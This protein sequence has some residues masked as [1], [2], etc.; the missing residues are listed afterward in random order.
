MATQFEGQ[1][2]GEQ[3]IFTFR[4]HPI[5]MRKG[6]YALAIPFLIASI[7]V[8]IWPENISNLWIAF[9]GLAL[10]LLLFFYHW[11]GWYFSIFIV[12]D[13]RLRQVTQ[14]GFF[15]RSVID[16]GISK[17]QN[18]SYNVPGFT[19]AVLGFGT[20]VVQTYVGD[21]YLEKLHHPSKI[22]NALAEVIQQ[23]AGKDVTLNDEET[24]T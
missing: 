17:I 12:T 13:H 5:V 23:Y 6:F 16:L 14:K 1:H 11:M 21:L 22:Y 8:L 7:P 19:A 10:G 4:R 18:I 3:V 24:T 15:N 9:G 2:E 20:M